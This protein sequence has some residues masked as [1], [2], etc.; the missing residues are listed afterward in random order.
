[1]ET[2]DLR[3]D[4][5]TRPTAAMLA[6][7]AAAEN[8]RHFGLREDPWQ[9]RLEARIAELVGTEDALVF[10]TCTMANT[11]AMMIGAPPGSRVVT[12]DG[13]HVL[14]SEAGAGAALGGLVMTSVGAPG[15]L[16]PIDA[17]ACA[18]A[19]GGDAQRPPVRL[20]VLE[21]THNRGGG[22]PLPR[23]EVAAVVALARGRNI[24]LHLDGSRLF[25]AACAFE[26]SA[27]ELAAGFS[28][29]S[30]SLNKGFGAPIAAA[31]A[32]SGAAIEAALVIR[33]RLGG[34]IRPT[35]PSSAA[36]LV[37]LDDF[38]HFAEVHALARRLAEG[39]S[40]QPGIAVE[41]M[42]LR[43]NMVIVRAQPPYDAPDICARFATRGLL[44]LPYNAQRIRF[45][46]YRG[47]T[48][49]QIERALTIV[50]DALPS[51]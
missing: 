36:T 27:A 10:P 34:G 45:I 13:A 42:P 23:D 37:A 41:A 28:T 50:R 48:A 8:S 33:Q 16:P 19:D 5:L 1:M 31:L 30:I 7:S 32:G 17:W 4:F 47:V 15:A 46:V 12:Q 44:V 2:I 9:R 25:N 21:N 51:A 22:V 11:T 38:A 20:C 26:T 39:L 35:G 49:A 29:V 43:T 18:F 3:S 40:T 24:G 14:V 6:A